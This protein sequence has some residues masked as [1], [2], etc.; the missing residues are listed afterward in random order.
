MN[1]IKPPQIL[2]VDDEPEVCKLIDRFLSREGFEVYSAS[3]G[4]AMR[5]CLKVTTI[6]LIILDVRLPGEDGLTLARE[7]RQN[8]MVPIIML[9]SKNEV[10]DRV[11]GLESGADD[12]LPKPFHPRELLAR[13][14]AVLRRNPCQIETR[15]VEA[16]AMAFG[17]WRLNL[18]TRQLF[19]PDGE[20][21]PLSP[22]EYELLLV[23]LHNPGR[24]LSRDFLLVTTRGREATP[25]DRAIDVHISHLRRKLEPNPKQPTVF[26]TVRNAGYIFTL[27]VSRSG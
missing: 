23:F 7:L 25:F 20:E 11:V 26:K 8:S 14:R 18:D 24:V 4:A 10:I 13:I 21:I 19:Q 2:V 1:P 22:A 6:D 12:Y 17:G 16:G 3:S 5:D 9:T 27:A 15:T